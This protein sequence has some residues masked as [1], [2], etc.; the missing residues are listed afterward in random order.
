[1]EID[2]IRNILRE[3]EFPYP[4]SSYYGKSESEA[5]LKVIKSRSP[6]RYYGENRA[7]EAVNF[8]KN[9]CRYYK[10][11]YA[12]ALNSGS[13]ALS[14]ALYS[15][16]VGPGSEVIVPGFFWI[17][18][19]SAVIQNGAIP[20]LAEIDNSLCLDSFDI[21]K[22]ITKRTKAII[23]I[24]MAGI[25]A[26]MT[27]IQ[28][29][30]SK[31]RLPILEDSAQCNGGVFKNKKVGSIGEV[32]IFSL[33]LNKAITS[34]EGGL[35]V[36]NDRKIYLKAVARHDA[37]VLR[38]KN[39]AVSIKKT[40]Y[41]TF[42]E[43]RRIN[44]VTAAL[45]N[46]QL[47]KLDR[48]V[49]RMRESKAFIKR[50]LKRC[51]KFKFRSVPEEK[52]DIGH[53]VCLIFKTIKLAKKTEKKFNKTF[54]VEKKIGLIRL[55]N[56]GQHVYFNC[57]ALLNKRPLFA[58]SHFPWNHPDNYKSSRGISYGKGLLSKTDDILA[59]S[60]ILILPPLLTRRQEIA[61]SKALIYSL[62]ENS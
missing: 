4:G 48:I 47:K 56:F 8:E 17:S 13:G 49:N 32:G 50:R 55:E 6:F 24:H 23:V 60:L 18:T 5:V 44:E 16:E 25:A 14:V 22:K 53:S 38:E 3:V 36:T 54:P 27:K 1:M 41:L 33:Q 20:I 37:G 51:N 28:R 46:A 39:G 43:G 62:E 59:R 21:E 58:K 10:T 42:G 34:G 30:A 61:I 9:A 26:D 29:L 15:L 40:D 2:K 12:L 11:K 7:S 57:P 31:Y 19:V 45:A 52:A 35:L